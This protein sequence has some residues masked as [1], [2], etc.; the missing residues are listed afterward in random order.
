MKLYGAPMPAPNPRR[1]R[2]FLAEKGIDLPETPVDLRK[3]EHKSDEHRARNSLGQVPTL[4]LD[5]GACISETV[6]ICRY[7]EEVSPE[8]RLFG[9]TPVEKA[10][11]D[12]WIRR[13]EFILMTPV[14]NFWRHA[15]PYTAALLTQYKEF[16]ESNR[17]AYAGG[18]R[19][20]D[21]ELDGRSY[22]AGE[23]YSMA[24]ICALS[25]VDFASWIGLELDPNLTHLAAWRE[26]VSARPSAKA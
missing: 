7:F 24:D 1:V 14:G 17:A 2:I 3:R 18:Q 22:I 13:I 8:P 23:T 21:R 26:R 12:M 16:G 20:L 15:H 10:N 11:V 4:E 9:G 6:A 5:D 19:W 25:T